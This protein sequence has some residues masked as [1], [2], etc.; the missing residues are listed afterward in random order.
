MPR[1]WPLTSL[2]FGTD[3]HVSRGRSI[4]KDVIQPVAIYILMVL[5]GAIIYASG[6]KTGSLGGLMG[7][8]CMASIYSRRYIFD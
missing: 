2:F 7:V 1:R 5:G 6:S 4:A 3:G 8:A